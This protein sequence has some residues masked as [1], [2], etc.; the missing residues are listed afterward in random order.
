MSPGD[1]SRRPA[2]S[3]PGSQRISGRVTLNL[4]GPLPDAMAQAGQ[5]E[6]LPANVTVILRVVGA[7]DPAVVDRLRR[8]GSHVLFEVHGRTGVDTARWM[9]A[10][11]GGAL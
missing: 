1:R 8:W 7:P 5:V 10:L 2:N 3:A 9:E 6:C 4:T 11:R